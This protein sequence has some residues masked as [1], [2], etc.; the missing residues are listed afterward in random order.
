MV[1]IETSTTEVPL[2]RAATMRDQIADS[3]A[4][5]RFYAALVSAFAGLAVALA[6]V[7]IY[8]LLSYTVQQGTR[9]TA[10]RRALGAQAGEILQQVVGRGMALA[11]VGLIVGIAG[12]LALTRLLESMLYE[13][14]PTD[15]ATL[16]IATL[17]FLSVALVAIWVPARRATRIDPM[18]A[19]R[20]EG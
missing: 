17:V 13:I 20:Y 18:E 4:E 7:G 12:S 8:G 1:A 2:F 19:M 16:I 15:P 11:V 6:A 9:E 10:I 5:P 3:V 14:E